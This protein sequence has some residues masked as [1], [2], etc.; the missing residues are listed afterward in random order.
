MCK[1]PFSPRMPLPTLGLMV[2]TVGFDLH[3]DTDYYLKSLL[4]VVIVFR[5]GSVACDLIM[6]TDLCLS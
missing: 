5:E 2:A 1:A 4:A 3:L 6:D